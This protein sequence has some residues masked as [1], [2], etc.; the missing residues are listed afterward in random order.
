MTDILDKLPAELDPHPGDYPWANLHGKESLNIGFPFHVQD[1][2]MR[3]D[4]PMAIMQPEK[5]QIP[6]SCKNWL[7]V[8]GWADVS[9]KN[10]G[11]TWVTLDAPLVEVGGIT[12]TLLGGQSNPAVW[13]KHIEPTQK[14]YSWALNNHWE[15]NYRAYQDGIITFRYALQPHAG[16]DAVASTK[17]STGLSQP[18]I[19][20]RARGA[21]LETPRLTISQRLVALSLRPSMDGKAWMLTLYNPGDRPEA[22][23]LGWNG[24][25]GAAHYSNTAEETLEPVE[26]EIAVAGQDVVTIRV[27]KK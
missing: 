11:I 4:I 6:G 24:S 21:V 19:V 10:Y 23:S 13:R 22:T 15:T 17:F 27:E 8:G 14:L 5:D 12:A 1:G 20:T 7:E 2:Q 18:L 3:L 25:V 9:N 26:G 16:Y